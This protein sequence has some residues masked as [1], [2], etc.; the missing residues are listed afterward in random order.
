MPPRYIWIT[1]AWYG[2]E[3]WL[4]EPGGDTSYSCSVD[5]REEVISMSLSLLTSD[6][7]SHLG[8]ISTDTG[9]VRTNTGAE[10]ESMSACMV[11][12]RH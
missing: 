12:C 2:D 9:I 1:F 4:E 7:I 8:N 6:F 5:E 11:M 10:P 3:W